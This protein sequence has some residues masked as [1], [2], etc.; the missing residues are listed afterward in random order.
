METAAEATMDALQAIVR[1]KLATKRKLEQMRLEP[2][3]ETGRLEQ[4]YEELTKA[5]APF[6]TAD[7]ITSP[8]QVLDR[9]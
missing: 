1:I 6:H 3:A 9:L 7:V 2:D 8:H 5:L 4:T